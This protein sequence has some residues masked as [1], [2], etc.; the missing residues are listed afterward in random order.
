[1]GLKHS[2]NKVQVTDIIRGLEKEGQTWERL[3]WTTGGKLELSKCLYLP[4]VLHLT[5]TARLTEKANMEEEHVNHIWS[6]Q[7][8]PNRPS[9]QLSS[10]S[11]TRHMADT[12]R[13]TAQ[14][15]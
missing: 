7:S 5:T 11:N 1:M 14:V 10:A 6:I 15:P 9:G 8:K 13:H 4:L 2:S 3:L 12:G